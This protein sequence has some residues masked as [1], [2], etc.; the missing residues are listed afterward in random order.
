MLT[1]V[2]VLR[3]LPG[4]RLTAQAVW[5]GG[6]VLA[7]I[8]FAR[9]GRQRQ[10]QREADGL[11]ALA[12][13]KLPA[14]RLL[15][16][17]CTQDRQVGVLLLEFLPQ[18]E[19]LADAWR[20]ELRNPHPK[21]LPEGEQDDLLR[22]ALALIRAMHRAGLCQKDIHPANF[23]RVLGQLYVID[24]D[25]IGNRFA[26]L[27][28]L[29]LFVAQ[30]PVQDETRFAA[31]LEAYEPALAASPERFWQ[32]VRRQRRLRL[33]RYWP[34][35]YRNCGEVIC[36]QS[37]E[38]CILIR[39]DEDSPAL[40][41]LLAELDV[42][43]EQGDPLKLGGSSTVV[44]VM[45]DGRA[46]VIKRY[47]IKGLSHALLRALRTSRAWLSWGNAH[48]LHLLGIATP[49][50]LAMVEKRWGPLRREAYFIAE[51][52]D[53]VAGYSYPWATLADEALLQRFLK[54]F[55]ALR[56]ARIVL[57]DAKLSNFLVVGKVILVTDLD[58]LRWN[59]TER[60]FLR[61]HAKD[62]SR[63]LRNWF[64]HPQLQRWFA[65]HLPSSD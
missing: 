49:K 61:G 43:M 56:A 62:R 24:G 29:A 25:A 54:I 34:K 27:E 16:V 41:Q 36:E 42:R 12:Q 8:F 35:L 14:P 5:R 11:Q 59:D 53:G 50:P 26:A 3:L 7:K 1:V 20:R 37:F 10:Q 63:F 33:Q 48:V 64:D 32:A 51:Y 39:R 45:L 19:T 31:L 65:S 28:N 17:G 60:R 9:R 58:T 21:P 57:G 47:N 30:F 46:V 18:A 15:A 44:K 40:R 52:A 38:R 4:K 2:A 22:T 13:A 55:Q 6:P 23:L